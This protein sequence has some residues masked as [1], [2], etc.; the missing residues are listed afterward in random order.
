MQTSN[1]EGRSKLSHT[2]GLFQEEMQ[3]GVSEEGGSKEQTKKEFGATAKGWRKML[4]VCTHKDN[5]HVR[6]HCLV[7]LI[8]GGARTQNGGWGSERGRMRASPGIPA[9]KPPALP[10]A[11]QGAVHFR[12]WQ[13]TF[14]AIHRPDNNK[15]G[16][17]GGFGVPVLS[18]G[19]GERGTTQ[20]ILQRSPRLHRPRTSRHKGRIRFGKC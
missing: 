10:I 9:H 18:A 6:A 13:E 7:A 17:Q 5:G 15:A 4:F 14:S 20:R 11:F 3:M 16:T 8:F 12:R 2:R 19:S 1:R